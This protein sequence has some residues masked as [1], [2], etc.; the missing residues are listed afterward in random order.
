MKNL[1]NL[2]VVIV[3]FKTNEEILFNCIESI[4][5]EI[6]IINVENSDDISHKTKIEQKY[7]NV[8]VILSGKN[9]GYGPANNLGIKNA[10][11]RYILV[12]NPDVIYAQ[13]FF[14][15]LVFYFNE[16]IDFSIIGPTYND[17]SEKYLPY[18]S[19]DGS[20]NVNKFDEF[21]LKDVDF[22]FGCSM[23]FDTS[24]IQLDNYYDENFFLYF[25]ETDL[26][27]RIKDNGGK[28]FCSSKLLITHLG[29]KG[30]TSTNP[31]YQIESEVIRSW[32]WMWSTFYYHKKHS[33]YMTAF[34]LM[35]GKLLRA[36]IKMIIFTIFFNKKKQK[37]YYARF[38]GL[39]HSMMGRKSSFRIKF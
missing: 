29:N 5:K 25:E 8:K 20:I 13:N 18:G 35:K 1:D 36:F 23:L 31:K 34:H 2:T 6:N 22:I 4:K 39:L 7:Q 9:L 30:S 16:K 3:T 15:E 14:D 24:K 19:F 33:G 10:K 11:T 32:H 37:M 21:F 38:S 12:S 26:C 17:M 27:R 28:I